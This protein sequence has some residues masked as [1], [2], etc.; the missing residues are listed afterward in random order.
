[1]WDFGHREG[2]NATMTKI[3]EK[4]ELDNGF[5]CAKSYGKDEEGDDHL[6]VVVDEQEVGRTRLISRIFGV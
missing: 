2:L 4:R 5:T 6:E 3:K 1:M